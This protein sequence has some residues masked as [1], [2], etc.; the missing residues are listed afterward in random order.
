M[1]HSTSN[2]GKHNK[3]LVVIAKAIIIEIQIQRSFTLI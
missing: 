1:T 2:N 3:W